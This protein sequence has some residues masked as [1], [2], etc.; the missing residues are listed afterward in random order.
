MDK[1]ENQYLCGAYR[2]RVEKIHLYFIVDHDFIAD[3]Q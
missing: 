3:F 1:A 2:I